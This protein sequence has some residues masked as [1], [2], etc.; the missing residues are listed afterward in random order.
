MVAEMLHGQTVAGEEL[1]NNGAVFEIEF[2]GDRTPIDVLLR[3]SHQGQVRRVIVIDHSDGD[4]CEAQSEQPTAAL[5][6]ID[7]LPVSLIPNERQKQIV[8]K[9]LIQGG[10]LS[11]VIIGML[12][13]EFF[14]FPEVDESFA[15]RSQNCFTFVH[16][17]AVVSK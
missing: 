13:E 16:A 7:Q 17:P 5:Y 11:A 2:G 4:M 9:G 1:E 6:S 8:F 15:L 14:K 3:G 12:A 10:C